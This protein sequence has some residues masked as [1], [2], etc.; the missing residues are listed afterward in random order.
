MSVADAALMLRRTDENVACDAEK[1]NVLLSVRLTHSRRARTSVQSVDTA[2]RLCLF[3]RSIWLR[4]CWCISIFLHMNHSRNVL[5]SISASLSPSISLSADPIFTIRIEENRRHFL[6]RN[7][8]RTK[9][10]KKC[11]RIWRPQPISSGWAGELASATST[12]K[13]YYEIYFYKWECNR[14]HV[15]D[16]NQRFAPQ[17]MWQHCT[18]LS[19]PVHN[20]TRPPRYARARPANRDNNGPGQTHFHENNSK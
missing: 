12:V 7:F 17:A 5:S 8:R 16:I 18:A 20:E 4:S 13:L 3:D 19:S 1:C 9:L 6:N 10:R 2:Y 11:R 15:V 14:I